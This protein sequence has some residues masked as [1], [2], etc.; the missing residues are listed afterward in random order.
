MVG[1]YVAAVDSG[2]FGQVVLTTIEPGTAKYPLSR[3][4]VPN[5]SIAS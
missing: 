2:E 5:Q 1:K 3:P 4:G